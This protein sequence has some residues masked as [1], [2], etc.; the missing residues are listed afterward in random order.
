MAGCGMIFN[1]MLI[2]G[3]LSCLNF[4]FATRSV[5]LVAQRERLVLVMRPHNVIFPR[6]GVCVCAC[7]SFCTLVKTKC[8]ILLS[9]RPA[10]QSSPDVETDNPRFSSTQALVV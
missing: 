9:L 4:P 5:V 2:S 3:Y 1:L 8:Q 10:N 6:M 7:T